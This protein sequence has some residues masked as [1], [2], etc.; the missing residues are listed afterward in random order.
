[1]T[2]DE[3]TKRIEIA[4]SAN[5]GRLFRNN[6][7]QGWVGDARHEG[8]TVTL[9]NARPLHA[10]LCTGSSDLIGWT[11]VDITPDMVGRKVAVFTAVEVKNG[12]DRAS[13]AQKAFI[14]AVKA[15]GGIAG[16]ARTV[17]DAEAV[18]KSFPQ[19]RVDS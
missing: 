1:M 11:T 19:K 12:S 8:T 15:Q 16:V 5:R 18:L 17:E 7:G 13:K 4:A 9:R 3:L 14:A 10:G 6:T 2:T